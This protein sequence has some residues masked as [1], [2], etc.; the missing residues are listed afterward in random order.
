MQVVSMGM[1]S[2]DSDVSQNSSHRMLTLYEQIPLK[3]IKGLM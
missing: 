1:L 3:E 2:R